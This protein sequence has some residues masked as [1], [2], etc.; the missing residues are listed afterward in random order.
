LS[1]STSCSDRAQAAL[2]Q[3]R[4][5]NLPTS[6]QVR[7][8]GEECPAEFFRIVIEALSDSFDPKQ[9]AS[10]ERLM[11]A[12]IPAS[13]RVPPV[14][15]E[16]VE[17]VCVLSRVTLGSDI[18]ITSVILDA[19]KRRFPDAQILFA[20]SRKSAELFA[21]DARVEHFE[22]SYPRSGPVSERLA[23][24]VALRRRLAGAGRIVIDPD[25]RF[26]QLGLVPVC[27][28]E[29]YFHFP[30]RTAGMDSGQNL[31]DLIKK[32]LQ[33]TFGQ[34][35]EHYVAPLPVRVAGERPFAAVSLGVGENESKR[36]AGDFEAKLIR[37]LGASFGTVWVDRG[38]GGEEALRVTAAVKDSDVAERVK[39]WEGSFAGF[40]SVISQ[41]DFYAGYDSAGQHVAAAAGV[42]LLTV[43]AGAAS[44]RFRHRWSADSPDAITI[45]ADGCSPAEVFQ[46]VER[47]LQSRP[48]QSG[49]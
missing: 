12:W 16:R 10:Y 27:E 5:G 3:I 7:A 21:A 48:V 32:W 11:S 18:K 38:A 33:E 49:L 4:G 45:D 24:A 36:V 14:L 6:E 1:A 20:G 43:F 23:F 28:P 31:S 35:G 42:P 17:S 37:A 40:A 9:V 34:T 39:F 30:S 22:A 44:E 15:P 41:S 8:L 47:A 29:H 19:M 46:Q 2:E 26:T 25:S 13:P